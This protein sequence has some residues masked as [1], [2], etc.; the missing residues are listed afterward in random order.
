MNWRRLATG[1]LALAFCLAGER[2]IV[3][4][5]TERPILAVMDIE[6]VGFKL[7]P[8]SVDRLSALLTGRVMAL[9]LFQ[10]VQ[11]EAVQKRLVEMKK[12]S[13][14]DCRAESCQIQLG[15]AL[16]AQKTLSAQVVKVGNRCTVN[17][18]VIDIKSEATTGRGASVDGACDETGIADSLN[19][20]VTR[21]AGGA[22]RGTDPGRG[23]GSATD[24]AARSQI[25]AILPESGLLR[26]EG[27]PAG[28]MVMISGPQ[29]FNGGTAKRVDLPWGPEAVPCGQYHVT[30]SATEHEEAGFVREVFADRTAVVRVELVRSMGEIN[31][32]GT[33]EGAK[34]ELRCALGFQ[35]AVGLPSRITVPRGECSVAVSRNGY[36]AEERTVQIPGGGMGEVTLA[37]RPVA[38]AVPESGSRRVTLVGSNAS[39]RMKSGAGYTFGPENLIDGSNRTC[40]QPVR[41]ESGGVGQWFEVRLGGLM[42]VRRI[43]IANGFQTHDRFGDEFQLNNRLQEVLMRT[44]DGS[45]QV[46]TFGP[47]ARGFQSFDVRV[48]R[49]SSLRFEVISIHPGTKWN[50]LAVSEIEVIGVD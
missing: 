23:S 12:D 10:V 3:A 2:G 15:V 37:L 36:V 40:W 25:G 6:V 1:V 16:S 14:S 47:E 7:T 27:S 29:K 44:S 8:S 9:G 34:V 28:A 35:K 31:I 46:L 30:A 19:L 20:A 42:E 39:S 32:R 41:T 43:R 24:A 38:A 5:E 26:I 49:T 50:D 18:S 13:Y 45:T 4:Q 21:I 48:K 33:P 17:M 22:D 11:R